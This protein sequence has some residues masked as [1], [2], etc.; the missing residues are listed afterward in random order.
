MKRMV[1]VHELDVNEEDQFS[2]VSSGRSQGTPSKR[3]SKP[4]PKPPMERQ[5]QPPSNAMSP[6]TLPQQVSPIMRQSKPVYNSIFGY[7][8][9]DNT[10][11]YTNVI[12]SNYEAPAQLE[13]PS[14]KSRR[15]SVNTDPVPNPQYLLSPN[16]N[17]YLDCSDDEAA[18]LYSYHSVVSHQRSIASK[19]SM[20]LVTEMPNTDQPPKADATSC[21]YDGKEDGSEEHKLPELGIMGGGWNLHIN[22]PESDYQ[23]TAS[24]TPPSEP[25]VSPQ[26]YNPPLQESGYKEQNDT[27]FV[28]PLTEAPL[29][30]VSPFWQQISPMTRSP[31]QLDYF[32]Q[33]T[34]FLDPTRVGAAS[35]VSSIG[36]ASFTGSYHQYSGSDFSYDTRPN[37]PGLNLHHPFVNTVN[38]MNAQD[39]R[40][41][42]AGPEG[43]QSMN[44]AK[45]RSSV[46]PPPAATAIDESVKESTKSRYSIASHSLTNDPDTIKTM[47]RMANL[48]KD[49]KTQTVYALYLLEVCQ[50][51]EKVGGSDRPISAT[52]QRLL[53]EAVYWIERLS[54]E[55]H[56]EATYIKGLWHQKGLHGYKQSEDKA[57][58]MWQRA[59]KSDHVKAK[60][61]LAQYHESKGNKGKAVAYYKSA[62][63]KGGVEPNFKMARI[64]LY[65]ELDQKRNL[66]LGLEYLRRAADMAD[67]GTHEP[68]FI[69]AQILTGEFKKVNIPKDLIHPDTALGVKYYLKAAQLGNA[70]ALDRMAKVCQYGEFEQPLD[71]TASFRYYEKAAD[72]GQCESM[73]NL[74]KMYLEG[75]AVE[76]NEALAFKWCERSAASGY[77]HAE[78]ALGYYYEMGIGVPADYPRALEYYGKAATK[79]NEAAAAA[80]NQQGQDNGGSKV[81]HHVMN[82]SSN[83]AGGD[84]KRNSK[85][86][87][88]M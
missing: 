8:Q 6:L 64:L 21:M 5:V 71:L 44:A 20:E 80:L 27:L 12:N 3:P 50:M 36:T 77:D 66:K 52:R 39:Y 83:V 43:I 16:N 42:W 41:S 32:L 63:A 40:N 28:D 14:V 57:Y 81:V 54:K 69:M 34:V 88:I 2:T 58:R 48:T 87:T 62:T 30:S 55:R 13:Q 84:D 17:D 60:F 23:S 26:D 22:N 82:R 51:H 31:S 10:E 4:L 79:G 35:P 33:P 68:A 73:L 76:L 61:K 49:H 67:A 65:G 72:R 18:S 47:R 46:P 24:Q 86:C 9:A 59:A 1:S 74:S 53:Q 56:G 45:Q 25:P 75:Q 70:D 78:F 11:T 37:S 15:R 29:R 85:E 7:N 19:R 38:E